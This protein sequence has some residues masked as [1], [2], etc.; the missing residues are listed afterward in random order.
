MA[1]KIE[2]IFIEG[3][4]V[5]GGK[6]CPIYTEPSELAGKSALPR[7][8]KEGPDCI[9]PRSA[10]KIALHVVKLGEKY[11]VFCTNEKCPFNI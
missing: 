6:L 1:N 9:Q 11:S 2:K 4:G 5:R 8:D 10:E 7:T 3:C